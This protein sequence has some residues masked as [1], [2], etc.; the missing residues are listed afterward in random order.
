MRCHYEV[1]GIPLDAT[2]DDIKKAYRKAALLWHP[3][4][5][6]E[7]KEE[8]NK[9]FLEVQDAYETLS[10]DQERAWYDSHRE[11]IINGGKP[12]ESDKGSYLFNIY[13]YF[14]SSCYRGFGNDEKG[15]YAVYQNMFAN[16]AEEDRSYYE[17]NTEIPD[18]GYSDS[19]YETVVGPFYSFWLSYCCP[20]SFVWVE[21]HDIREANDRYVRRI[22]EK[23]NKKA[24]DKARKERNEEI[25]KI[26]EFVRKK[27]KRVE[28]YKK[29]L[30]EKALLVQQKVKEKKEAERLKRMEQ[31]KNLDYDWSAIDQ[32]LEELEL[33]EKKKSKKKEQV[34]GDENDS[35]MGEEN[36]EAIEENE[37]Q[38]LESDY[39]DSLYCVA[40]DKS[41]QSSKS[42]AN[43]EKSKKHKENIELLK[44]HM[45]TEDAKLFEDKNQVV[46]SIEEE[47]QEEE[48][49]KEVTS[50][51]TRTKL[52]K[53][54]K[55]KRRQNRS[56]LYKDPD[57][58]DEIQDQETMI[59][60]QTESEQIE[61]IS[62]IKQPKKGKLSVKLNQVK[63]EEK[64]VDGEKEKICSVCSLEFETRNKLFDHIKKEEH[65]ALKTENETRPL[66]HNEIKKNKR[67]L[68]AKK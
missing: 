5:H 2:I 14:S 41:F 53:K 31:M 42:F 38:D 50:S 16:I 60:T 3:D 19:D 44:K 55:K 15:F 49:E 26:V 1:L 29:V 46:Q 33:E 34:K 6:S 4:K 37:Q 57:D 23:E 13:P 66:S 27:D 48:E 56:E 28:N 35:N 67:L 54:Q 58:S 61:I 9:R 17:V 8:A 63:S 18:F 21:Q 59:S 39:D 62:Q 68:K 7:N 52:S 24:R 20:R 51:N 11:I 36:E 45:Q 65:Y 25:R 12:G 47:E 43:H 40:C 64:D 10:N 22:M 30:E 32:H